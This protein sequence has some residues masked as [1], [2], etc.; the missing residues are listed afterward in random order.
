MPDEDVFRDAVFFFRVD[1]FRVEDFRPLDAE[2]LG[3]ADSPSPLDSSSSESP[4]N[5]LATP[6]AAGIATPSA[7]PATIF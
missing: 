3:A 1:D 2:R 7:V 6:T 5:F 4:I